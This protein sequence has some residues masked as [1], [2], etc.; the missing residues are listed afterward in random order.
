MKNLNLKS[1]L[2][3]RAYVKSGKKPDNL[4]S[5]VDKVYR[6]KGCKKF[7]FKSQRF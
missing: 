4:P 3:Y 7:N 6:N 5:T 1:N 2:E